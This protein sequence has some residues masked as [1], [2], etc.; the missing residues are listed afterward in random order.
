MNEQKNISPAF[1]GKASPADSMATQRLK[2]ALGNRVA[3]EFITGA[4][5]KRQRSP[6][7]GKKTAV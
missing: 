1:P 3:I 6:W 7:A 2:A 5:I 4:P